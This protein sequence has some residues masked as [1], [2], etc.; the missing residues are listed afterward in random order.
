M[1][2]GDSYQRFNSVKSL[3]FQASK[4]LDYRRLPKR[5]ADKI[6]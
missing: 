4:Q 3:P 5:P 1:I 2:H 6:E